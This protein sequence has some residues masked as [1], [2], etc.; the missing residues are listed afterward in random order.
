MM[1]LINTLTVVYSAAGRFLR[2]RYI[3]LGASAL[4]MAISF[5]ITGLYNDR[6]DTALYVSQIEAFQTLMT[7]GGYA[8]ALA[9]F[10]PLPGFVGALLSFFVH[11]YTAL[12]LINISL[13][14][15]FVCALYGLLRELLFDHRYATIGAAWAALSYPVLKY[16]FGLGTDAWGWCTATLIIMLILKAVRTERYSLVILA[17]CVGFIGSLAKETAVLGLLFAGLYLL[18]RIRAR[19]TRNTLRWLS[20]LCFPFLLFQT[21]FLGVVLAFGG[22]TFL[23]WYAGNKAQY[24]VSY[25][26]IGYFVGV[27]LSTFN[28]LLVFA[29]LGFLSSWKSREI[30]TFKWLSTYVPLVSATVPIL[31][32][33]IFI[34]RIVFLHVVWIMPLA[35]SGVRAATTTITLPWFSY[36]MYVLPPFTAVALYVV[37]SNGSLFSIL[38]KL[39]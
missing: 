14:F 25:H 39:I 15:G 10:K 30:V 33:P 20:A 37:S 7:G 28:V 19:G 21:I 22:P 23:D 1:S 9:T 29:L 6:I 24:G 34:S 31:L 11:P 18:V 35:L 26:H 32:W 12:L 36:L 38:T 17:S 3:P 2:E 16:G 27:M 13:V 8:P 5:S 4:A